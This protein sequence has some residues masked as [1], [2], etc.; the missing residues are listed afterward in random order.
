MGRA[1]LSQTPVFLI[2]ISS[3][4]T[5]GRDVEF[6]ELFLNLLFHRAVGLLRIE[7][8]QLE[9]CD[10]LL[11]LRDDLRR[12]ELHGPPPPCG[13]FDTGQTFRWGNRFPDIEKLCFATFFMC[14]CVFHCF[15]CGFYCFLYGFH[16]F[17][18]GFYCFLYGFS[19][20]IW[21]LLFFIWFLLLFI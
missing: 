5:P 7:A 15:L 13:L 11:R 14:F 12:K 4:W 1:L 6:G 20:F 8:P 18:Y 19:C 9:N 2:L 21:F 16:C 10:R 17:L 3:C